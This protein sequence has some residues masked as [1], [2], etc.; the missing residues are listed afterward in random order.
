M[1]LV[2]QGHTRSRTVSVAA[3][4]LGRRCRGRHGDTGC[5]Y[6][7][8]NWTE[9]NDVLT[10]SFN[11]TI[12][13]NNALTGAARTNALLHEQRHYRDFRTRATRMQQALARAIRARQ[14]PQMDARWTWFLYDLC[15][16][17]AAFHRSVGSPVEICTEPT[18]SRP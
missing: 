12:Y 16:D 8:G 18:A 17:S 5:F 1:R 6:H 11:P 10:V 15:T 3:S 13:I 7:H 14:D 9:N 2:F 4:D